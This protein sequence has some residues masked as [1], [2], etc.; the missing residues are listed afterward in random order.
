MRRKAGGEAEGEEV[1]RPRFLR[2]TY[3]TKP[4]IRKMEPLE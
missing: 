2:N 1:E 4:V 3:G